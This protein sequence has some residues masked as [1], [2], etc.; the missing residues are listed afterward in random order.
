MAVQML[1]EANQDASEFRQAASLRLL[2][3]WRS[4]I[5]RLRQSRWMRKARRRSAQVEVM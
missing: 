3:Y 2:P 4:S 1:T 5:N